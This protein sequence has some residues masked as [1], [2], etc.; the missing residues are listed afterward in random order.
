MRIMDGETQHM[1][2]GNANSLS[3]D[4]LQGTDDLIG[5]EQ[6]RHLVRVLDNSDVTEIEVKC[7]DAGVRLVLRKAKLA[8][9][10]G[11]ATV[12]VS[13][14]APAVIDTPATPVPTH[15]TIVAPLVGVFHSWAKPKGNALVTVGDRVEVGQLVATIQSLNVI[16][17]VESAFAGRVSEI[18]VQ[19]GQP[20]EYGQPLMV[21][22][23]AE[24]TK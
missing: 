9:S 21:I 1:Y 14:A 10:N 22:E 19:D 8:D 16:N 2:N 24:E 20:V 23:S 15:H 18:L 13:E 5:M 7:A 12:V 17:E 6:L 11:Q 4:E 3:R